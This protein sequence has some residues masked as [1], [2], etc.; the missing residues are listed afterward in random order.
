MTKHKPKVD[1]ESLDFEAM[2]KEME[3]DEANVVEVV[4]LEVNANEGAGGGQDD[5]IA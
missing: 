5:P 3:V 4:V 1:L 2:D